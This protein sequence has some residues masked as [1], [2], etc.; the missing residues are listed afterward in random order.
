MT[1]AARRFCPSSEG[2]F[3]NRIPAPFGRLPDGRFSDRAAAAM[4]AGA[5]LDARGIAAANSAQADEKPAMPSSLGAL[6]VCWRHAMAKRSYTERAVAS[7]A[8]GL[9]TS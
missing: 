2:R 7:S 3:E 5:A 8:L 6:P 9:K 1:D 4:S